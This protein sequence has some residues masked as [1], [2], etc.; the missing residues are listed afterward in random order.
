MQGLPDVG[1][2]VVAVPAALAVLVAVGGARLSRFTAWLAMLGPLTV[3]AVG[4]AA[5]GEILGAG[6]GHGGAPYVT[7]IVGSGSA[8]WLPLGELSA[9]VG[10]ALDGM[11]ALMLLV[12]GVVALAVMVFSVGYM[13]G[14]RG[15]ARYYALLSLFTAAMTTLVV[16]DGLVG[17]FIGW[18]LVGACSYLLIGF[19]FE[20]PSAAAAARKAFL[21][22]RVGDVG[23]LLAIALLWD[24]T[25]SVAY[26]SVMAALPGVALG[27]V[28][29]AAV[30][31]F[32]GAVGKSAQFPLHMWLPDAMEGPTPVSALIHAATM[33]A[34]G[35]FL[36]ARLWPVFEASETARLIVLSIGTFTAFGAATIAV[37]QGD[38]K[39]VLAYSTISQLGFMFAALGA[40][41]W[42]AAMLHLTTHAAFKSLLF[43]GAGSVIHGAGTQELREMGGLARKMP[44]T[45]VTWVVGAAALAGIP[46]LS[47]FV[48]K[49]GVL[50]AV[51]SESGVAGAVLLLASLLTAFYT[52]RVTK[53]AFGD[54]YRGDGHPH[55]GGA[56]MWLPLCGLAV[57]AAGLGAAAGPIAH[58]LGHE[59]EHLDPTVAIVSGL[60]ALGGVAVGWMVYGRGPAV[61]DAAQSRLGGVWGLAREGWGA[62]RA[63]TALIERPFSRAA[64]S[65]YS[66]VE[67]RVVDAAAEG[68]AKLASRAG[69]LLAKLQTGDT[70]WYLYLIAVGLVL[71]LALPSAVDLLGSVMP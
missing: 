59:A 25:G 70:Q 13:H 44:V 1:W 52:A 16:A 38:I 67:G 43:L 60:I 10:W 21:V 29:L 47:G 19:W 66:F 58:L 53:L 49:D 9:S 33:V 57:L 24:A 30:L 56:V 5:A 6:E 36:V 55:E 69:E 2:I 37:T 31:L 34:A 26:G 11:T 8:K 63:V 32:A 35:V 22:T 68:T 39:K 15:Y 62:D 46:P 64:D 71:L 3:L 7:A 50:H 61:D 41:A 12:V 54:A 40:G 42:H 48:S 4:I 20:K 23:L 45:A 18:E 17:L 28:T 14:E 27:A 51:L 65:A